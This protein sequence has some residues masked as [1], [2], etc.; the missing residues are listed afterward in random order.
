[1]DEYA[2]F[3]QCL[4]QWYFPLF[5]TFCMNQRSFIYCCIHNNYTQL[6]IIVIVV[7]FYPWIILSSF[8]SYSLSYIFIPPKHRK[9]FKLKYKANAQQINLISQSFTLEWTELCLNKFATWLVISYSY[10]CSLFI[11]LSFLI[12]SVKIN[13]QLQMTSS[14]LQATTTRNYL[15]I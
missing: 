6:Y 11:P 5:W 12:N 15:L 2:T 1:M 9:K 8:V 3:W 14:S 4:P 10:K 7:Q 13:K